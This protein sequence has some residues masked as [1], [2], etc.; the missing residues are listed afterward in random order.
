MVYIKNKILQTQNKT[1]ENKKLQNKKM[2]KTIKKICLFDKN[3]KLSFELV[4]ILFFINEKKIAR[5]LLECNLLAI[6]INIFRVAIINKDFKL[7]LF[8][9][10]SFKDL[11]LFEYENLHLELIENLN[12]N[13]SCIEYYLYFIRMTLKHFTI[14]SAKFLIKVCDDILCLNKK[15]FVNYLSNPFKQLVLLAK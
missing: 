11:K 9:Y 7:A 13:L 8:F 2:E 4:E 12:F 6:D 1:L 14:R 5:E 3:K 15:S 10:K